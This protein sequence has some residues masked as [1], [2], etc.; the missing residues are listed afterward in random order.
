MQ[1]A[2]KLASYPGMA[3]RRLSEWT[4]DMVVEV[5]VNWAC[6]TCSGWI[7]EDPRARW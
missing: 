4:G 7:G 1:H 6:L 5:E 3:C 2:R